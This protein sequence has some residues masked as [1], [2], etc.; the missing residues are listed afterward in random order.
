MGCGQPALLSISGN[1]YFQLQP[2]GSRPCA[3]QSQAR[4]LP[5][6]LLQVTLLPVTAVIHG[7]ENTADACCS[8][9]GAGKVCS[10]AAR[11]GHPAAAHIS[12]QQRAHLPGPWYRLQESCRSVP[13]CNRPHARLHSQWLSRWW[14]AKPKHRQW[15][16]FWRVFC[17]PATAQAPSWG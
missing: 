11:R 13:A 1:C 10:H 14:L 8:Q 17:C 15:A 2:R 4:C 16:C 6:D 9:E 7:N 12:G 3:L 5:A